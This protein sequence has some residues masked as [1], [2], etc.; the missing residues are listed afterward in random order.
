MYMLLNFSE[1]PSSIEELMP[2]CPSLM[3][4]IAHVPHLNLV[5]IDIIH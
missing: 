3:C 4:P 5:G 1:D 2:M